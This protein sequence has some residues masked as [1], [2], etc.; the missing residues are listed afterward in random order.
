[1]IALSAYAAGILLIVGAFFSLAAT[2]GLLRFPDIYM[3]LHAAAKAGPV[4]AGLVLLAIAVSAFDLPIAL[5]ALAGIVFLLL[6]SPISAHLLAR[7]A[8]LAGTVPDTL[9]KVNDLENE[10]LGGE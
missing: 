1:V 2:I 3:R 10:T 4:G 6:T 5:R 9:T 8:Y 7:A